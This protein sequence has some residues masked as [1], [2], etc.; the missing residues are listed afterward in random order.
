MIDHNPGLRTYTAPA[1]TGILT[2]HLVVEDGRWKVNAAYFQAHRS[3]RQAPQPKPSTT[4]PN[5]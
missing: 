4:L 3:S 1:D 5:R 2:V